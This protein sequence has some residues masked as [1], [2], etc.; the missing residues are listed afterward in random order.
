[1]VSCWNH[2]LCIL[3]AFNLL[4][5][6]DL[7]LYKVDKYLFTWRDPF[8]WTYSDCKHRLVHPPQRNLRHQ[9]VR[10]QSS[11]TW[12]THNVIHYSYSTTAHHIC[13]CNLNRKIFTILCTFTYLW[14]PC[15]SGSTSGK[16]WSKIVSPS[17]TLSPGMLATNQCQNSD[18]VLDEKREREK[19]MNIL[20]VFPDFTWLLCCYI[21]RHFRGVCILLTLE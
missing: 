9:V 16:R 15:P 5:H 21:P 7:S 8:H 13:V 3:L 12:N 2:N 6:W 10:K 4:A 17:S 20:E 14:S 11:Q 18:N 1:M 19:K